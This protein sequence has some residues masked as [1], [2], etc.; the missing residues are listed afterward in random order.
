MRILV[1]GAAGMLG[2]DV[3]EAAAAA[4]AEVSAFAR[5]A[6]DITDATAVTAAV[7]DARPDAVINCAAWT[8]VDGAEDDEAAATAVN[9]AGAGHVAAA[10]AAAGAWTLHVSSDYV[11]DGS[12][13][14]P[15]V[16]SDAVGPVSAYGRSKL[17]GE[18]AAA[19]AAPD[20]HT[21]VRSSWLFGAGG[22]CFPKT[23]MRLA[24][25][26]DELSVVDDQVGCP[27]FTADLARALLKLAEVRIPG[28]VHAAAADQCSWFEFASEI[29]A[30]AG[31]DCEVK[32]CTTAEFPRPAVRPA[33]SVMRTERGRAVPELPDW[34]HGLD[35]FISTVVR[36]V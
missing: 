8:D 4:G 9:G 13:R 33:Y 11:F 21:I 12:K 14:T 32:P 34:R 27:T 26:R 6:L 24:A 30:M 17:A 23:I 18:A 15:Y 25:D 22:N 29:V 5:A 1:T 16:E 7:A 19:D 3:C 36:A 35:G 2:Q 10:A 20:A 28:V 31:L